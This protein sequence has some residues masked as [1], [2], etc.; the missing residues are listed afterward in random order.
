MNSHKQHQ[1]HEM[2]MLGALPRTSQTINWLKI[3]DEVMSPFTYIHNPYLEGRVK[4][5]FSTTSIICLSWMS[6]RELQTPR[7]LLAS[8]APVIELIKSNILKKM[9]FVL[10]CPLNSIQTSVADLKFVCAI[11]EDM[12]LVQLHYGWLLSFLY[13]FQHSTKNHKNHN[14]LKLLKC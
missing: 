9:C 11:Y 13:L 12:K 1:I 5:I 7:A 2:F 14:S 10:S 3:Q 4:V 8:V 6:L